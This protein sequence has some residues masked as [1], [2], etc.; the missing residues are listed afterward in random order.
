MMEAMIV[1]FL[2]LLF[3]IM[4]RRLLSRPANWVIGYLVVVLFTRTLTHLTGLQQLDYIDDASVLVIFGIGVLQPRRAAGPISRFPGLFCFIAFLA[5]GLV[6]SF[7]EG[8]SF[9]T[10]LTGGFLAAKGLLAGWS[11]SRMEWRDED[12]ARLAKVG[13]AVG[14][15]VV[16][17]GVLNVAFGGAWTRIFSV[18]GAPIERYGIPSLLSLFIHPFDLAFV[19]S[20]VAIGIVAYRA[21][22]EVRFGWLLLPLALL[23]ILS[24]RRK[25]LIGLVVGEIRAATT[26]TRVAASLSVAVIAV[27]AI[28]LFS[29]TISAQVEEFRG[30]YLTRASEEA[31]TALVIGSVSVAN[32]RMPFGAGFGQF[33]SRE[34][35]RNYSPIY[36]ELGL[37]TVYGLGRGENGAFLTDTSWPAVLGETGY[38]GFL[39]FACGLLFIGRAFARGSRAGRTAWARWLGAFGSGALLLVLFESLGAAVFTSPPV[40][41]VLF[42]IVGALVAA[43]GNSVDFESESVGAKNASSHFGKP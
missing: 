27:V 28:G 37:T 42:V 20:L 4:F 31:R 39:A 30:Q 35:A 32:E 36:Q 3:A 25:D 15:A 9:Q 24:L 21:K 29:P 34:A 5:F 12:I 14:I 23:V 1:A 43:T 13:L 17:G 41:P 19:A 10:V 38:A 8:V 18:N 6:S 7:V 33:G 40:Y 11:A 16:A 2:G 26:K 22:I